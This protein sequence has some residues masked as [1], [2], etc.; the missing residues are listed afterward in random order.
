MPSQKPSKTKED[1]LEKKLREIQFKQAENEYRSLAGKFNLPFSSLKGVPVDSDSL[2]IINEETARRS[3]LVIL[4]KS[5]PKLFVALTDPDNQETKKTLEL[6]KGMN[7]VLE[8]MITTPEALE[9]IWD[10]YK[11]SNK[12]KIF[13]VGAIELDEQELIRLQS[14]IRD[15]NDLKLKIVNVSVTKLL[16]IL[17]AGALKTRA[18]DIHFEPERTNARLRY[19]LDGILYDVSS[20]ETA[21][22]GKILN[23]IKIL[24]KLKLN[25]HGPQEGRFSVRQKNT[26]IDLRISILPSEF[27]ETVVMRI[28]DPINVKGSLEDLGLR[29]DFEEFVKLQLKKNTGTVLVS[30]PTGAGKTTTLYALV[31]FINSSRNKILTIEDPIEYHITGIS[32][33][34]VDASKGYTFANGLKIIMRQNPDVILVGEIRDAETADISLNASLTGHLVLTTIHANNAAGAIPRLIDLHIKPEVIAPA[35]NLVISQRLIRKLCDNCKVLKNPTADDLEKI[36]TVL[37][38]V[39]EKFKLPPLDSSLKIYYPDKCIK[40]N[41]IGYIGR[42][43]AFEGFRVSKDFE[44]KLMTGSFIISDINDLLVSEGMITMLQDACL[45]LLQGITSTEEIERVFG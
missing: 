43:A 3:H 40:C 21:Y 16:E 11:Q 36:K 2:N 28:L 32:Q 38:P 14:E 15:L 6:L 8:M 4:Y 35:L 7:F 1:A 13:E 45:K 39:R 22:Y 26:N 44:K 5:P 31:N 37:G 27:G 20:I 34:Q 18:S 24:S 29:K 33:S 19:R 41:S 42:I 12:P 10:R 25:I 9:R 23:R 30:G 17:M